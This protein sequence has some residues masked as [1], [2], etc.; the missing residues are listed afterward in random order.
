MVTRVQL[1]KISAW[2]EA[3]AVA[4]DVGQPHYVWMEPDESKQAG[5]VVHV[6]VLGARMASPPHVLHGPLISWFAGVRLWLDDNSSSS[7]ASP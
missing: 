3:L 7:A 6:F 1:D 4:L 2:L 5:S